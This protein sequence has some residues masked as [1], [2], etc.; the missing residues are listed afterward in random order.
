MNYIAV[1]LLFKVDVTY[2]QAVYFFRFVLLS[3][4][5]LLLFFL[6]LVFK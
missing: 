4:T 3:L 1:T 6:P 5:F 2:I